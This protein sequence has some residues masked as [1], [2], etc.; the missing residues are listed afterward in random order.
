[1]K[2]STFKAIITNKVLLYML[3]RYITYAISFL[4]TMYIASDMG[5][6][7]YGIWGFFI[8]ILNYF[9]LIN[10]GIPQAVQVFFIRNKKDNDK[11]LDYEKTGVWLTAA[12]SLSAVV[13]AVLYHFGWLG[14]A[15]KY[16]LGVAF[17]A[18]CICGVLNYFNLLYSKIS[19]ARNR[20]F[21]ISFQQSSVVLLMF[22]AMFFFKEEKLLYALIGCYLVAYFLSFCLYTFNGG[23]KFKGSFVKDY[24]KDISHKGI[25][26]F[27]YNS[28]FYFII[29]S[30]KTM[31][32]SFYS[33]EEF[34]Y[35][36]FAYLLG[37]AVFQ[38]L[39]AFSFLITTKI[40][41]KYQSEDK[42]VVL[43][44]IKLIRVNYVALFHG[45]MYFAMIFFP[46]LLNFIPKYENT[47]QTIYLCCL[48]MLLYTNSFGYSTFLVARG[49]EKELAFIAIST[50]IINISLCFVIIKVLNLHFEY[51][52]IATM[53]AYIYYAVL[54]IYFGRKELGI[55]RNLRD[56]LG[57]CFPYTL[58]SLLR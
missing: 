26:L 27:L 19:R 34:G 14:I 53:F 2:K 54:C 21:E 3:T 4:V 50:L 51:A 16:N 17:Y 40:L 10:W 11:C 36:T 31:V 56:I 6:Y 18:V 23:V 58:L 9:N 44:T 24:A 38:L 52:I 13:L 41:D 28:G 47:L 39:E 45:V 7:Y 15:Y 48:T 46:V 12:I 57:D 1:M 29:V 20:V 49:R 32:S 33:V 42:N 30:T 22:V 25:F 5:P 43:S 8:L 35:F 55:S 37:H